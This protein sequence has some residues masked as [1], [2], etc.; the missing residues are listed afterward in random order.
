MAAVTRSA[1]RSTRATADS[2]QPSRARSVMESRNRSSGAGSRIES[3]IGRGGMSMVYLAEHDR[4][5]RKAALKLLAPELSEN[6]SFRTRFI[7]ESELAAGLDHPNVIPVYDAGEAEGV[8]YI[9]MRY[10]K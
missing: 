5:H 10:V 6:E 9:A 7:R 2:R 8:L 1:R 3:L 4:L